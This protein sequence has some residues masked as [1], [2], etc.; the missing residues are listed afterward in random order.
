MS[1]L[2]P[3]DAAD[4]AIINRLQAGLPIG[5]RPFAE[6][7]AALGLGE[8]DLIARL[9]RLL[10]EGYLTRFGPLY[11]AE[12][13]G[14][15]ITLAA[16]AVPAA[17]F[18]R[19]AEQVNAH[20]EIAHNYARDHWLNLWFVVATERPGQIAEVLAQIAR[21]TGLTVYDFPKEEEFCIELQLAV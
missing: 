9:D 11:H 3:L 15:G 6:A 16:M 21:E 14:G 7:A 20:P 18:D 17:D 13:M 1:E 19:V 2:P 5:E 8:M 4:R 12:R 10:Q